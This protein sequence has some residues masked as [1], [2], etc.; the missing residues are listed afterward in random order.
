[1]E[2]R[3]IQKTK[4]HVIA[5]TKHKT[6]PSLKIA[7]VMSFVSLNAID[8]RLTWNDKTTPHNNITN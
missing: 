3:K 6:T 5:I 2:F 1:M 7:H 4:T 8:A